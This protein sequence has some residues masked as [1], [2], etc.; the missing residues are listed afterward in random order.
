MKYILLT[1][2]VPNCNIQHETLTFSLFVLH[3]AVFTNISKL[4]HVPDQIGF[5]KIPYSEPHFSSLEN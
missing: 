3:I 1:C 5:I 2:I 4:T